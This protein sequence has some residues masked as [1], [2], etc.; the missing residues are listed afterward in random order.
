[1]NSKNFGI[2]KSLYSI[3][4]I[5]INIGLISSIR[6]LLKKFFFEVSTWNNLLVWKSSIKF[7][8]FI[9]FR[10]ILDDQKPKSAISL[11]VPRYS[12]HKSSVLTASFFY[13]IFKM[14]ID[15]FEIEAEYSFPN[16]VNFV[17]YIGIGIVVGPRCQKCNWC[18]DILVLQFILLEKH[19]F[20]IV[21]QGLNW[22]WLIRLLSRGII[23]AIVP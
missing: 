7:I 10:G 22:C 9:S 23:F 13:Q 6:V 1:M 17:L 19:G 20:E 3:S 2:D 21:Y 11:D 5:C 4:F 16:S 12:T 18:C 14:F 15:M 8:D